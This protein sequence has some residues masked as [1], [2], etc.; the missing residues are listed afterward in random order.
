MRTLRYGPFSAWEGLA[1][2]PPFGQP[3]NYEK[4]LAQTIRWVSMCVFPSRRGVSVAM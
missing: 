4:C 1:L 2:G 3:D